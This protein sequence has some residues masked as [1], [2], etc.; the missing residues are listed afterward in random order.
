[1]PGQLQRLVARVMPL[2]VR[3]LSLDSPAQ[4]ISSKHDPLVDGHP[5]E[6]CLA[7]GCKRRQAR[8]SSFTRPSPSDQEAHAKQV[9]S[10]LRSAV[11]PALLPA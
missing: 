7:L 10:T 2:S 3:L 11:Q 9:L 1:M 8:S 6:Q 5:S 4:S